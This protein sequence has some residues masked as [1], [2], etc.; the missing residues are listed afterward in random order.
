MKRKLTYSLLVGFAG[1]VLA[2]GIHAQSPSPSPTPDGTGEHKW[3]LL[4]R[5]THALGLS[6]TQA[7][8]AAT[9]IGNAQP[10]IEQ[11]KQQAKTQIDGVL[12]NVVSQLDPS[13]SGSQQSKL[14][15]IVQ[16]IESRPGL[17]DGGGFRGRGGRFGGRGGGPGGRGGFGGGPGGAGMI[18]HL[19]KALQL[20]DAQVAQIQPLLQSSHTQAQA[21]FQ[22]QNLNQQQKF[23]QVSSIQQVTNGQINSLLSGQQQQ[24]FAAL[25]DH[26]G[27]GR[28]HF[29]GPGG[30]GDSPSPSTSGS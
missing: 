2:V 1:L 8:A 10:Q 9:V 3:G 11:I 12:N 19:T 5:L 22:N 13:L 6:D 30:G 18:D 29:H 4:Q 17:S 24:E 16:R 23:E 7:A 21:I 28:G 14:A 20:S 15:D 27:R 26:Q 25:K